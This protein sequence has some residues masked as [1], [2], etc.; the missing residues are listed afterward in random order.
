MQSQ[1]QDYLILCDQNSSGQIVGVNTT[2]MSSYCNTHQSSQRQQSLLRPISNLRIKNELD[3][4]RS[5]LRQQ[6]PDRTIG[7]GGRLS[8]YTFSFKQFERCKYPPQFSDYYEKT[9]LSDVI[10]KVENTKIYAH[11]MILAMNSPFFKSQFYNQH[12][13]LQKYYRILEKCGNCCKFES[14]NSEQQEN[15][16]KRQIK[17]NEKQIQQDSVQSDCQQMRE[18]QRSVEEIQQQTEVQQEYQKLD[19]QVSEQN[20]IS[21]HSSQSLRTSQDGSKSEIGRKRK[22]Q[23][24]DFLDS[25]ID[26][27]KKMK[28]SLMIEIDKIDILQLED[29]DLTTFRLM[30]KYCYDNTTDLKNLTIDTLIQLSEQADRFL[31]DKLKFAIKE[32][33]SKKYSMVHS[34][35]ILM[36][37][38]KYYPEDQRSID[39]LIDSISQSHNMIHVFYQGVFLSEFLYLDYEKIGNILAKIVKD[40]L[41]YPDGQNCEYVQTNFLFKFLYERVVELADEATRRYQISDEEKNKFIRKV[42]QGFEIHRFQEKQILDLL[43]RK[44]F[45]VEEIQ[46]IFQKYLKQRINIK[47]YNDF[48]SLIEISDKIKKVT[49]NTDYFNKVDFEKR[50]GESFHFNSGKVGK[51]IECEFEEAFPISMTKIISN[52]E[53]HITF[54]IQASKSKRKWELI[55]TFRQ[56][57]G[58]T[59]IEWQEPKN[60]KHWRYVV[61]DHNQIN[62]T[63]SAI[64]W[65]SKQD[66]L[67]QFMEKKKQEN[68][69]APSNQDQVAQ[70]Q[71]QLN[72]RESLNSINS[73]NN[74]NENQRVSR[75]NENANERNTSQRY[76]DQIV[77][78]NHNQA[79][80]AESGNSFDNDL[81]EESYN[82]YQQ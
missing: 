47:Y 28:N 39:K 76:F 58:Q 61:V 63:F 82:T 40:K 77:I 2:L 5:L 24:S 27:V 46:S 21:D 22:R 7:A 18:E 8:C 36:W 20:R 73:G 54:V 30:L 38:H 34:L 55:S 69:P 79:E 9:E 53:A 78:I 48:K 23:Q 14:R 51:F 65:Y 68:E 56:L 6:H 45:E 37:M 75:S 35:K 70:Q 19:K 52:S 13:S 66:L 1:P 49:Y 57:N 42:I 17:M 59:V 31:I 50:M 64:E 12:W 71:Q 41:N 72:R 32:C 60:F 43:D 67:N 10:V 3:R 29:C 80:E 62:A 15:I 26:S 25:E 16:R 4:K 74:Q 11:K 44:I 33:L 81:S